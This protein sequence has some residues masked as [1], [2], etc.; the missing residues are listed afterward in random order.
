MHDEIMRK[1][2]H[3]DTSN[4]SNSKGV[5]RLTDTGSV[6]L[7]FHRHGMLHNLEAM[8]ASQKWVCNLHF[9]LYKN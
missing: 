8:E 6:S 9:C 5:R 7:L 2:H 3:L 1:N 4:Q